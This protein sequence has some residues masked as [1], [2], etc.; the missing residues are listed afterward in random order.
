M[1]QAKI[2]NA[3]IAETIT[4]ANGGTGDTGTFTGIVKANSGSPYTQAVAGTDYQVALGNFT[5]GK[6]LFGVGTS[7]P[8]QSVNLF[9]DNVNSRL[10]LGTAT[11]GNAL[12]VAGTVSFANTLAMNGNKI[13]GLG[14]PT[15]STDAARKDY[16][17]SSAGFGL[18]TST[19]DKTLT[20]S[21]T[22]TS[23]ISTGIGS[24]TLAAN[25][26]TVAKRISIVI[27]SIISTTT[28]S[29]VNLTIKIKYGSTVLATAIITNLPTSLTSGDLSITAN[30]TCRTTGATGSIS[31]NGAVIYNIGTVTNGFVSLSNTGVPITIDT[32]TSNLLDITATW[33][34]AATGN[35][36]LTTD[37]YVNTVN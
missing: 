24:M 18:F 20:N 11:P 10:G 4:T 28:P 25:F 14:S 33:A 35:T 3:D 19:A 17:D 5:T 6:V 1:T 37:T 13:L 30:A 29:V 8:G 12:S 15:L 32:T 7:I 34:T 16:V 21:S 9:W 26:L 31:I 23:V 2:R 22:E 36:L 27:G